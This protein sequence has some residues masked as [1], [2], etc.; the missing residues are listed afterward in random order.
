M[1]RLDNYKI[2]GGIL[3]RNSILFFNSK[4][5][6]GFIFLCFKAYCFRG[7]QRVDFINREVNDRVYVE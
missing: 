7:N 4:N 1:G 2:K 3:F 6:D 5:L